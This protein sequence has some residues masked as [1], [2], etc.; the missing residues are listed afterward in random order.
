M[1]SSSSFTISGAGTV[2]TGTVFSGQVR[3]GDS[4]LI[5]PAG[6]EARVRGLRAQNREA[7]AGHAGQRVVLNL[8]G[9]RIDKDAIQ[10]GDWI[11]D[12]AAHRPT[13]RIEIGRAHV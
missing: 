6:L 8:A 9:P 1:S 10:R 5:S 2:I 13:E 4:V 3:A 7:E 12:P 11:L